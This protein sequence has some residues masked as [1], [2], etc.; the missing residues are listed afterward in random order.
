MSKLLKVVHL[1]SIAVFRLDK[2]ISKLK[3]NVALLLVYMNWS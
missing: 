2:H 3:G 1:I